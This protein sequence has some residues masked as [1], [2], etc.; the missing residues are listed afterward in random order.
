MFEEYEPP[1]PVAILLGRSGFGDAVRSVE[2][3][4]RDDIQ[5]I[6]LLRSCLTWNDAAVCSDRIRLNYFC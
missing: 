3:G 4:A 6:T 5:E 1:I 2:A